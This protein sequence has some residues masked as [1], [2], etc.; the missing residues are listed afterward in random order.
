MLKLRKDDVT[1][2]FVTENDGTL[3]IT[4]N[5]IG[6]FKQ[7][8]RN[9]GG[10]TLY[11]NSVL[12]GNNVYRYFLNCGFEKVVEA[13]KAPKAVK[14]EKAEKIVLT[15]EER[16]TQKYGDIT[17]RRAYIEAKKK[18]TAEVHEE[19]RQWVKTHHRLDKQTWNKVCK[20]EIQKRLA[21]W[22]AQN[23]DGQH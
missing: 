4:T 15:K 1:V 17:V 21:L 8:H 6:L 12:E 14:A 22:N 3:K 23:G 16:L 5:K 13:P 19:V 7:I 2:N 18:I 9:F 11:P 10:N 20:D